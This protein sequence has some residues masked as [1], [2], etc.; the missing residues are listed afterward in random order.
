M[1][2]EGTGAAGD[3]HGAVVQID[4]RMQEIAR[5][6]KQA[7]GARKRFVIVGG[8]MGLAGSGHR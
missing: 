6:L 2:A 7:V 3:E 5:L 8:V 1:L 4:R